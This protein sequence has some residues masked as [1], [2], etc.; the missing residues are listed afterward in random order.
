MVKKLSLLILL[1]HYII[2]SNAYAFVIIYGKSITPIN[3]GD[4]ITFN[5]LVQDET[6]VHTPSDD[7]TNLLSTETF[8]NQS[9]EKMPN[10]NKNFKHPI[11]SPDALSVG[12]QHFS[13]DEAFAENLV[14]SGYGNKNEENKLIH[15][16]VKEAL[17][18]LIK[19]A[20]KDKVVLYPG[21][22]FRSTKLQKSII[23]RKLR[24]NQPPKIIY[25][26]SSPAGYSEH[27][28]GYA[29]DFSPIDDKFTE[30]KGYKWLL[31]NAHKYGWEQTFTKEY[32]EKSGVSEESWHWRYVGDEHGQTIFAPRACQ[33]Q[34]LNSDDIKTPDEIADDAKE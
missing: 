15:K 29:V 19:A 18:T 16:D 6:S 23:E 28:T 4:D 2:H 10:N 1:T 25:H 21:S 20:A 7:P 22:I 9:D 24:Q 33:A 17:Q 12:I 5:E 3:I 30:H 11:C 32:S 13:Y 31:K 26:T 14:W 27:H 34:V 8:D